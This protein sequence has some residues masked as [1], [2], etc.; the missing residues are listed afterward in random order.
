[1][2]YYEGKVNSVFCFIQETLQGNI[3]REES[4]GSGQGVEVEGGGVST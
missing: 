1:M 2:F 3:D 4:P